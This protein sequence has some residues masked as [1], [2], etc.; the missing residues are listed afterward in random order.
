LLHWTKSFVSLSFNPII[1][2]RSQLSMIYERIF[3]P[4][5]EWVNTFW[6]DLYD[7][8]EIFFKSDF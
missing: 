2:I 3:I 1:I 5:C 8:M 7:L 6:K 4:K